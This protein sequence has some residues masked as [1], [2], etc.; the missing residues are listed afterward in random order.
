MVSLTD[1]LRYIPFSTLHDGEQHLMQRF[2]LSML[3]EAALGAGMEK[4]PRAWTISGLG[5]SDKVSEQFSALP[6]VGAELAAIVRTRAN[7][8][9]A[10][11]G[12]I[13]LN[14]DFTASRYRSVIDRQPPVIHLATHFK[15][16]AGAESQSYLLLGDGS[17]LSLSEMMSERYRFTGLDLLTLSACETALGGGIGQSGREVEGLGAQAQRYGA[18]AVIATLWQVA[19]DSTFQ[20]MRHFYAL[21]IQRPELNKSEALRLSQVALLEGKERPVND[22]ALL[23]LAK[24]GAQG[25][26]GPSTTS[27]APR[28]P[29]DLSRAYAHP[30]YWAPFVLMGN[31]L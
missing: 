27:L 5:V 2:Q 21:R 6:S 7:P 19:D 13:S 17:P 9:G 24:R 10:M 8:L 15:F 29:F 11:P 25:S 18:A 31:W 20:L 28:F 1:A 14:K 3:T 4:P 12:D 22:E 16:A 26:G 23:Q 30:F